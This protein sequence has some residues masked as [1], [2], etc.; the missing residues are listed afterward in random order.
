MTD[1]ERFLA[2]MRYEEWDRQIFGPLVGAWPE[3]IDRWQREGLDPQ[4]PPQ[5][6]TDSWLWLS[7]WFFPNPPFEHQVIEEDERSVLYVNKEGILMRE[8]KD[9]PYSSMPQFVRFPVETRE[10]FHRFWAERM[11]PDLA[12]RIGQNYAEQL[13]AYRHR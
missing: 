7:G 1:R 5:W 11:Q 12:A 8:R 6:P 4:N 10:D 9:Q 13:A 3:T 2:V